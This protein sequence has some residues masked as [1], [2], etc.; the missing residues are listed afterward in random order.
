MALNYDFDIHWIMP[1]EITNDPKFSEMLGDIGF[2]ANARGNYVALFRDPGT[3]DAIRGSSATVRA[4]FEHCGFGFNVYDSGAPAG[5]Y[6]KEDEAARLDVLNRMSESLKEFKLKD[7]DFN[8]FNFGEFMSYVVRA[9]PID[10]GDVPAPPAGNEWEIASQQLA[11]K[12]RNGAARLILLIGL[13][14][15]GAAILGAFATMPGTL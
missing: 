9:E 4:F 6:P 3:A 10:M 2:N 13:A 7:E 5:R 8:G 12:E 14:L 15:V 11:A 1:R